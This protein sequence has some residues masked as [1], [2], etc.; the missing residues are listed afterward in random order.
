MNTSIKEI[1]HSRIA[2]IIVCTSDRQHIHRLLDM[3]LYAMFTSR[4][5]KG[6]GTRV[7][8]I[9]EFGYCNIQKSYHM[10]F[11]NNNELRT[12]HVI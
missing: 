5:G 12:L 7:S 3:S 8:S 10:T 6:G 4:N 2:T 11:V 1:T 9:V